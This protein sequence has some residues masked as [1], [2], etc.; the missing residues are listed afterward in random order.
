MSCVS[1]SSQY[2]RATLIFALLVSSK[3]LGSAAE[4]APSAQPT[5]EIN[6]RRVFVPMDAPEA[7]PIESGKYL[8]V[9][10]EEFK[11]WAELKKTLKLSNLPSPVNVS[12]AIYRAEIS[13]ENVLRGEAELHVELQ[14]QSPKLLS[15]EPLNLAIQSAHWRRDPLQTAVVGLWKRHAQAMQ[16][17][18][19]VEAS[20]VLQLQWELAAL[21]S[22]TQRT[23]FYLQIPLIA[24]QRLELLLPTSHSASLPTGQRL[25]ESPED[26]PPGKRWWVFQLA[27]RETHRLRIHQ[28]TPSRTQA[29]LPSVSQTTSYQLEAQSLQ[30]VSKLRVEARDSEI[31]ELRANLIGDLKIVEVTLDQQ[32]ATWRLLETPTKTTLVIVR[33]AASQP[34]LLTVRGLAKLP[35]ETSTPWRLPQLRL[36]EVDWTEGT[37]SLIVSP[38]LELR[39]IVPYQATL[40]HIVGIAENVRDGEVFRLQEWEAAAAIEIAWGRPSARLSALTATTI[41][42]GRD[43]AEA[44]VVTSL[45]NAGQE[46]YQIRA[47]VAEGWSIDTVTTRPKTALSAWHLEESGASTNLRLQLDQAVAHQADLRLEVKAR[48]APD[49]VVFPA[50]AEQLRLLRFQE[51]DSQQQ[52]LLLRDRRSQQLVLADRLDKPEL[53]PAQLTSAARD[54]L[55]STLNGT[56]LDMTH[57]EDS[58]TIQLRPQSN[59]YTAEVQIDWEVTDSELQHRYLIDCRPRSGAV[60]EVMLEFDEVLPQ[61]LQ[62]ELVGQRGAISINRVNPFRA[63]PVAKYVLRLPVAMTESFRLQASYSQP[64][65]AIEYCNLVNL[66]QTRDWKGRVELLGPLAG[67]RVVDRGWPSLLATQQERDKNLPV[68]GAYRLG[69]EEL[70]R[71]KTASELHVERLPSSSASTD[72][73]Q[74]VAWLAEHQTLQ[75]ADGAALH[76]TSYSLENFGVSEAEVVL[77]A[78]AQ[79]QEAWL[80]NRQL[81]PQQITIKENVCRFRFSRE[82]RWPHLALKY[83]TCEQAPLGGAAAIRPDFPLCNFPIH[84][85]RWTLWAPEQYE[86]DTMQQDYASQRH[87]WW[88]RIFGPLARLRGD[89]IFNPLRGEN[90]EQL[91]STPLVGQRTKQVADELARQ[92]T[93]RLRTSSSQTWGALL[94]DLAEQ[95]QL[96]ELL[97]VDHTAL[98]A[99]GIQSTTLC[100]LKDAWRASQVS[101]IPLSSHGFAL[102]VSPGT[103]VFTTARRVAQWY[104]QLRPSELPGIFLVHSDDFMERLSQARHAPTSELVTIAR[105]QGFPPLSKV[106]WVSPAATELTDVGR[107]AQ[108]VDFIHTPPT[109][110]V[111]R[112][113]VQRALW[114]AL[115]LL[116]LVVGVWRLAHFPNFMIALAA[117]AGAACL[118]VPIAW[119]TIPQSVFLGL[120]AAA[121]VRI[122]LKSAQLSQLRLLATR[123]VTQVAGALCFSALLLDSVEAQPI[124]A[125]ASTTRDLPQVLVPIDSQG[126]EQGNDVYLPTGLLEALRSTSPHYGQDSAEFVLL[127]ASYR[128]RL[129]GDLRAETAGDGPVVVEPWNLRWKVQTFVPNY[130]LHLPLQRDEAIWQQDSHR[131]DGV[132]VAIE[133][134]EKG[135]CTVTLPEVGTHWLQ[136]VAQPKVATSNQTASLRLHVPPLSGAKLDLSLGSEVEA[137][138]VFGASRITAGE[139]RDRQH[140]QLGARNTIKLRWAAQPANTSV[141]PWERIEQRAWLRVDPAAAR[142]DIQ[143]A[144]TGL[145]ATA[146]LLALEIS[147]QLK[148][149][150]P[151]ADSPIAAVIPSSASQPNRLQL[152][153]HAGLPADLVIPLRFELQRAV[154]VGRLLFPRVRLLGSPPAQNLFAVSVSADLT[155][156]DNALSN[157]S[158]IEPAEF[159]AVW[160]TG[161]P[162][163]LYAYALGSE[164]P[165]WSLRVWPSEPS[166]FA[167]QVVRVDCLP[168]QANVTFQAVLQELTQDLLLHRI[169]VP[170]SIVIDDITIEE[171]T[172]FNE[173]SLNPSIATKIPIRWSRVSP[174]V[175]AVFLGRPVRQAHRL[176]LQG[177]LSATADRQIELPRIEL[178]GYER[179]EIHLDLYRQ[180][181]VQVHWVD[182]GQIPTA[183]RQQTDSRSRDLLHVGHFTW[184]AAEI[185]PLSKL[186]LE[187]NEQTFT[188]SSVTTV[189]SGSTNWSATLNSRIR[190]EEGILSHL[191]LTVPDNFRAPYTLQPVTIGSLDDQVRETAAGNEITLRLAQPATAGEEL[192]VQ[193][194]GNLSLPADGR[195]RVPSLEWNNAAQRSRFL[196]LPT[197]VDGQS[198]EWRKSGLRPQT[199]PQSLQEFASQQEALSYRI[200]QS[201]FT[202]EERSLRGTLRSARVR[203]VNVSGSLNQRGQ[204]MATAEIILQPGRVSSCQL[205]LPPQSQLSQLIVGNQPVRR[206]QLAEWRWNVPLGKPFLPSRIVVSYRSQ[207]DLSTRHLRLAA[208]QVSLGD[209][210]LPMPATW[211]RIRPTYRLQ[212]GV[213]EIGRVTSAAQWSQRKNQLA[214]QVLGDAY[215]QVLELPRQEAQAWFRVWYPLT[216]Q[217]VS[218][219]DAGQ[220]K[221]SSDLM[222]AKKAREALIEALGS[223][224]EDLDH[225]TTLAGPWPALYP[226]QLPPTLG[227]TVINQDAYFISDQQGQ[228]LL[229]ASAA[230]PRQAWQWFAA[231]ALL[232]GTLTLILQLRH[233]QDWHHQLCHWP[234]L[235]AL[236]G[237]LAWWLLL[238]PS[239]VGLL[240]VVWACISLA[241]QRWRSFQITKRRQPKSPF[242]LPVN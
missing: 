41:E 20:D 117:L 129:A 238:K 192:Q 230:T 219:D 194:T 38:R 132:P 149:V 190:I 137:L 170:E 51:I 165:Q 86:I 115:V 42:L 44:S 7:W 218:Q 157:V 2:C 125:A 199:L 195:L 208:P 100:Q 58:Q 71:G 134:Q 94:S 210:P 54:L 76:V 34:Q 133:W 206:E 87:H 96:A 83:S 156:D 161:A 196:L 242:A 123:K 179:G 39:S 118:V 18:V 101:A 61:D 30:V 214:M 10:R 240:V 145:Q 131:L 31:T 4:V 140:Y 235:F 78:R 77:P 224:E 113:F 181:A 28:L 55:P 144:I 185:R 216:Q 46:V 21:R 169:Q 146:P 193:L 203:H 186:Q 92:L 6:F 164:D 5:D 231:A 241:I 13:P 155:Y 3:L 9:P 64:A 120:I 45:S 182:P 14:G 205:Q 122:A 177:H 108:T 29:K 233:N 57:W 200:E 162:E 25:Q 89:T 22:D 172:G 168:N 130:R 139:N 40:Q 23:D 178:L 191:S 69:P 81:E 188:T 234:H 80:D 110:M 135:G 227:G 70:R 163:P 174:T 47:A 49:K 90:W 173:T 223:Q 124:T 207:C 19:L 56:L 180:E 98:H 65:E 72:S 202:A 36:Q 16:Q 128:G 111:R 226:P 35:K 204:F 60:T 236:A 171:L 201:Q 237:G 43:E 85:S 52:L 167:D 197:F 109:L 143:I 138:R 33:P 66:P 114:Y 189:D 198:L 228:L 187:R 148:L 215:S 225:S 176:Q 73:P 126:K 74:A 103:I 91:W 136:L 67:L 68:L 183:S 105:W 209:K 151:D 150:G 32:L 221:A 88:K 239:A 166:Y 50:T 11:R 142:L 119:L 141:T 121:L 99:Q 229:T 79:L 175:V 222:E 95:N 27:A 75:A 93:Q 127:A 17:A 116:T 12:R 84:L 53:S 82:Q 153:L 152:Q 184:R 37:V 106:P 26:A 15:L 154:S 97:Y 112:A 159:S 217:T 211:W 147:P 158:R 62:W 48:A 1:R 107:H 213:P 104:D 63:E 8:P 220:G 232:C 24:P 59:E 212:L 160:G 102:V